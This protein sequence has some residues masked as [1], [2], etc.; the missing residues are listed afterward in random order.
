[1]TRIRAVIVPLV[2]WAAGCR[3]LG[4]DVAPEQRTEGPIVLA[5]SPS[6]GRVGSV[7][8]LRGG[9]IVTG[10]QYFIGFPGADDYLVSDS[11]RD[12]TTWTFVPFGARSGSIVVAEVGRT[13]QV[14]QTRQFDVL[15][16][17]DTLALVAVA[18]DIVP[19]I[20]AEES[21]VVDRMGFRRPWR[22][23]RSGDS[24]HISQAYSSGEQYREYHLV[25]L[26]RGTHQLPSVIAAWVYVKPDHPGSYTEAFTTGLLKIQEFSAGGIIAGRFFGR[27]SAKYLPNG[28]FAFYV[29]VRSTR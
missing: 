23:V 20:A 4:S 13:D 12:S 27:P 14:G 7:V 8:A 5:A 10:G 25:L 28:T 11:T 21:S 15:E 16:N 6:S 26:D 3:D 9:R 17:A 19:A 18:Y 22:A 24:V 2:M 1:L 29:H